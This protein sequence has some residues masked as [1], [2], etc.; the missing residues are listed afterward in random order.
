MY[1]LVDLWSPKLFDAVIRILFWTIVTILSVRYSFTLIAD[2]LHRLRLNTTTIVSGT[3]VWVF[4]LIMTFWFGFKNDRPITQWITPKIFGNLHESIRGYTALQNIHKEPL[5]HYTYGDIRLTKRPNVYLFMVESYGKILVTH[6]DFRNPY[7]QLMTEIER[8]LE[9]SGWFGATNYSA[10]PISGGKSWLSVATVLSGLRVENQAIYQL[11]IHRMPNYPHFV[12]LLDQQGY[13]TFALQPPM[14]KRPE[15]SFEPY[16]NYYNFDTWIYYDDLDYVGEEYGW[17]IIPD[18][19]S[20]NYA[21]EK[22]IVGVQQPFFLFFTTVTSHAP[23]YDLPPYLS[24]W[25]GLNDPESYQDEFDQDKSPGDVWRHMEKTYTRHF[26]KNVRLKDA[27]RGEDYLSHM[28]YQMRLIRD[29]II[30]KAPENSIIVIIGDH[31]PPIFTTE[32]DGFQ[33]PIHIISKDMSFVD[34][35]RAYGFIPGLTKDPYLEGE[36]R[37]EGIYSMLVR[38]LTAFYDPD[39]AYS[40][41]HYHPDGIPLSILR[42]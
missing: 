3:L 11:L 6:P 23:W 4:I 22:F 41:P 27:F 40:L 1:L 35:F 24:D 7:H 28:F 17:S 14:R 9:K 16:Q 19:Y 36:I 31:Q 25:Q 32:T 13:K 12:R 20:L 33:T 29:Y 39:Q 21:H 18:Q 8:S 5:E 30:Q 2:N 15:F 37:H 42:E 26:R 10:A 34:S 38:L